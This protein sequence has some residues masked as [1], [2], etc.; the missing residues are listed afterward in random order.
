MAGPEGSQAFF[1]ALGAQD[2]TL[3]LWPGLYHEILNEP[4][5]EEVI[6]RYVNWLETHL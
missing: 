5:S 4:E 6:T 3:D 1:D 2:K